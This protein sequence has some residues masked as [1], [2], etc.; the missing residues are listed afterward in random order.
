MSD[1]F[2]KLAVNLSDLT[3]LTVTLYT[4]TPSEFESAL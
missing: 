4:E 3:G 1:L 2:R